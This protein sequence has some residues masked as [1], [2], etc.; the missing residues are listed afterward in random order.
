MHRPIPDSYWVVD[1]LLLAG[2]YAGGETP[3][4]ARYKLDALLDAGIRAFFDL[5]EHLE[6]RPYDGLL[7]DLAHDR[8]LSVAYNRVPIRDAGV[9]RPADLH[10]LLSAL[11]TNLD[12][13]TPSYVHC[14]GGIGRT[15]TVIGCWLVEHGGM[16]GMAALEH[17]AELRRGTPDG[18][19][20][21]PET[22]EQAALVLGWRE[23]RQGMDGAGPMGR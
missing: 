6:L 3:A 12:G 5:T 14:W 2:E 4:R 16:E 11:K 1:G 23:I 10:R 7:R 19:M 18:R 20:R 22:D 21:S 13:G 8:T 17:I 9:P 15:G